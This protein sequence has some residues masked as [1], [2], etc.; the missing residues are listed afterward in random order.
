MILTTEE[1]L[2]LAAG[3]LLAI[4]RRPEPIRLMCQPKLP[5]LNRKPKPIKVR[6]APEQQMLSQT[7][8]LLGWLDQV[9]PPTLLVPT[10]EQEERSPGLKRQTAA[11]VL[12]AQRLALKRGRLIREVHEE[13]MTEQEGSAG[14]S[15]I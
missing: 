14:R 9:L 6:H 7:S 15:A 8:E 5:T 1:V 11:D 2:S 3:E 4:R 10:P 13:A 12:N